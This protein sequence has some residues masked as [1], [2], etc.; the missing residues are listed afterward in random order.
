MEAASGKSILIIRDERDVVDLLA[1]NLRFCQKNCGR[2]EKNSCFTKRPTAPAEGPTE[3]NEGSEEED[4][5]S[6]EAIPLLFLLRPPNLFISSW[7]RSL[8]EFALP[9]V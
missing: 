9:S 7:T 6:G 8:F 2:V 5:E 4:E 3:G 1:F